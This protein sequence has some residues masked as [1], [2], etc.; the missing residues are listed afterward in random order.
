MTLSAG[1]KVY[2][3]SYPISAMAK[4]TAILEETAKGIKGKNA[5]VLFEEVAK[6]I[7]IENATIQS[8][9]M[10]GYK[11]EDFEKYVIGE[12]LILI[13]DYL[14]NQQELGMSFLYHLTELLRDDTQPINNA[15][16][17]YLLSRMEPK[18]D[19]DVEV[20]TAYRQFAKKMYEWSRNPQDRRQFITAIYI[21]VYLNRDDDGE[22]NENE[23][24]GRK[25]C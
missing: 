11:W 22:E 8:V 9:E 5:V 4:E 12:K 24:D 15:R 2:N 6:D 19:S 1:I 23:T 3:P 13:N 7:K 14:Q 25:L 16:Y 20:R 18:E 21:Y 10:H 17:V